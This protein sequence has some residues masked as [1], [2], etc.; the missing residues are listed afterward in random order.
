MLVTIAELVLPLI[1][2]SAIDDHIVSDKSIAIFRDE[3]MYQD[4]ISRYKVL[5]LKEYNHA[6][7]HFVVLSSSDQQKIDRPHFKALL[8]EVS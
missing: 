6:G 5:K 1:Q 7:I 8:D 4:F 2:R 3:Q